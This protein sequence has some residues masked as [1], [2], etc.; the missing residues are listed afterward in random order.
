[1]DRMSGAGRLVAVFVLLAP[2]IACAMQESEPSF[3]TNSKEQ[4]VVS[5]SLYSDEIFLELVRRY[6]SDDGESVDYDAWQSSK[7]DM[8][9]LDE[10]I[11]LIAAISPDSHPQ[12]FSSKED[13]RRYGINAYN[14][15]VLDAVLDYWPLDSVKDVKL[16]LTSRLIPGK[17]FFHDRKVVVGGKRMGLLKFEKDVLREQADPRLHFALNCASGS[18]PII[19]PS[20][21]SDEELDEAAREFVNDT[22]NV[23]V[24]S[25]SVHLSNI[26][27]WYKRDFPKDIYVYLSQFADSGLK[28]QLAHAS[29]ESYPK[30]YNEY[31]W[32]LNDGSDDDILSP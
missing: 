2:M 16:S 21:W 9:R 8:A 3:V 14:A 32:S 19:R 29:A 22:A 20:A 26:F 27:K 23:R 5:D 28:E 6:A 13:V 15:L 4:E 11:A 10:Q 25:G 7:E 30:R 31:D 12:Q 17:G 18:C 1:M 24:E